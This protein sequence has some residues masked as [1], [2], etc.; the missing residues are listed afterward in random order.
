M[1]TKTDFKSRITATATIIVLLALYPMLNTGMAD[2]TVREDSLVIPTYLVNP[3]NPMPRFYEGGTHQGVQRR[4]YPYPMNDNLTGVKEDRSYHIVEFGNEYIDLDIMPGL[5]GRIYSALDKTNNYNWFYKNKVIKP[6]LI[7]MLG[8]WISGSNA[9]GFPHH[10][11]PNTVKPMDYKVVDHDDGKLYH[12]D[13][14][15]GPASP[16]A[17][18]RRIYHSSEFIAGGNDHSSD[19]SHADCQFF[20]VLGQSIR[21]CGHH[22]SG[23]FSAVCALCHP[24]RQTRNDHLAGCGSAL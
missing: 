1:R 23:D 21:A 12:L 9:W 3:P 7:G 4:M 14:Q 6:S 11:G 5:G 22:L 19:E 10:H 8:Y 16:H 17:R 13:R 20:F 2:I 15:Y 24:A 18:D